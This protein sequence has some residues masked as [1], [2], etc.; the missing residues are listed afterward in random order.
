MGANHQGNENSHKKVSKHGLPLAAIASEFRGRWQDSRRSSSAK[1]DINVVRWEQFKQLLQSGKHKAQVEEIVFSFTYPRLDMEVCRSTASL[2]PIFS[3]SKHMNHLLKAP[4][5]VHPKTG[6]VCVPID[7]NRCDDFDPTTVPTLSQ[8]EEL[9]YEGLISDID[10]VLFACG[11]R[12]AIY[13]NLAIH[14][15]YKILGKSRVFR[16]GED[17]SMNLAV[18]LMQR[19]RERE[20]PPSQTTQQTTHSNN[21]SLSKFS[22]LLPVS[23]YSSSGPLVFASSNA[24]LVE[25][26][27]L[28]SELGVR[29][30]DG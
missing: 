21:K 24:L 15:L 17:I 27:P 16:D 7:P 18:L 2:F 10:G 20:E 11:E 28:G 4:F 12:K 30:R 29:E 26:A 3:V 8:I 19:L 1:E 5:C 13:L 25:E 6:R 14:P 22:H 23:V 9:N